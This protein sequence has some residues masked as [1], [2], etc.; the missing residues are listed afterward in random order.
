M[1]WE[2]DGF[3]LDAGAE[4]VF[5]MWW[6]NPPT[7]H[8]VLFLAAIPNGPRPT[9]LYTTTSGILLEEQFGGAPTLCNYS[10]SVVNTGSVGTKFKIRGG[11]VD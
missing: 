1:A 11:R 3:Y 2:V 10:V 4:N 6:G 5:Y 9:W 8:G 7:W